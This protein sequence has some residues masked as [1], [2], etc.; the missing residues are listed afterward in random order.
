VSGREIAVKLSRGQ[1]RIVNAWPLALIALGFGPMPVT[2]LHEREIERL[3]WHGRHP[4]DRLLAQAALENHALVTAN[5]RTA[6]H[7]EVV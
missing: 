7:G 2:A 1:S 5:R 3:P 4:F 6:D